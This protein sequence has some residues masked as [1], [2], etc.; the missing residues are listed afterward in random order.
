MA[1]GARRLLVGGAQR[2]LER[3]DEHALLDA[4]LLL[5]RLNALDDLLA[6]VVNPSSIRLARTIGVVRDVGSRR[7]RRLRV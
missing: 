7:R 5:D 4:L 2:I 3:G 6:H 1:G